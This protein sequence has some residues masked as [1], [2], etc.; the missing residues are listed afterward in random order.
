MKNTTLIFSVIIILFLEACNPFNSSE[1]KQGFV[2]ISQIQIQQLVMHI[3]F[4]K[5][6]NGHYP[7]RLE[8]LR[9]GDNLAPVNDPAQGM[10]ATEP[11]FYNYERIGEKYSLFSSAM[12]GIPGTKDDFYP[13]IEIPDSSKIGLIIKR[14]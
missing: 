2:Q 5:L 7:D 9:E 13:Q 1:A 14:N 4:Y 6:Q 10:Q 11:S 3:E 8:Q 12:D